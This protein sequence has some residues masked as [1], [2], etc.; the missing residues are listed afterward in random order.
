[1][2]LLVVKMERQ[3]RLFGRKGVKEKVRCWFNATSLVDA[4]VVR[5]PVAIYV[6]PRRKEFP[7]FLID[8]IPNVKI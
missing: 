4:N 1:M 8:I 7:G 6:V 5:M 2:Q 3:S